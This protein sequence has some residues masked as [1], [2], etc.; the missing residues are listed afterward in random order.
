ML[1]IV[2][3]MGH[4]YSGSTLLT[5]LL[6]AHPAVATVG[7]VGVA[8]RSETPVERFT[9]SCGV[10]ILGC[11]FWERVGALMSAR[12]QRLDLRELRHEFRAPGRFIT[13]RAL[14]AEQRG[15]LLE[16]V[17]S[18]VLA[19]PPAR[20]ELGRQLRF[21][22][23]LGQSILEAQG[24]RVLLDASKRPRRA[25]YLSRAPGVAVRVIHLVRDGRAVAHSTM[26]HEKVGAA[27]AA[28][29]WEREN[30][31]CEI[32]RRSFPASR[33]ITVRHEDVCADAPS[34]LAELDRFMGVP[35]RPADA[36]QRRADHHVIGNRM[37]LL[38]AGPL[39]LDERWRTQLSASDRAVIER[40][41]G[42][43]NARYG[44][45]A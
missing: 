15:P 8:P 35:P 14:R 5:F 18:L 33:W 34:R 22:V 40:I 30:R 23:D 32:V 36:R 3:I 21:H 13:D 37:R 4:G 29:A 17:R 19:L 1:D 12:R 28:Q 45:A 25:L 16:A 7:E 43:R 24:G 27:E 26:R 42:P 41:V 11:A 31:A 39:R 10:P 20:R 9:C 6:G 2:Y 38:P 44:Y